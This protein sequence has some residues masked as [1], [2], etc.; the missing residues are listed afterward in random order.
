MGTV[1]FQSEPTGQEA[2]AAAETQNTPPSA[3]GERPSWLPQDFTGTP[4][5]YVASLVKSQADT[6]AELT[7][8]QQELAK[9]QKPADEKKPDEAKDE[10]KDDLEIEDEPKKEEGP[11]PVDFAPYTQEFN[12]TGDVSQESRA[13][14]I[15]SLKGV[16]GDNTE[17]IVNDY[18]EGA[19][20][21]VSNTTSQIKGVAGGDEGYAQMVAWASE[22]LSADEKAAYNRAVNSGDFH[23]ASFAVQGLKSKYE[24]ANGKSPKLINGDNGP[25]S[26]GGFKSL[27]ELKTA[28][29]D[30]RYKTDPDYR[31]SV[32]A[33][34]AKSNI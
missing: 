13:K 16:F 11:A 14:I 7:R 32:E 23:T 19:K 26:S 25:A 28:I 34:A 4:E 6:K 18:I 30:P 2:P 29:A 15:D 9:Y 24:A 17:G 5:E 33:R 10:K 22:N 31:K 20:N 27:H 21:R 3:S 1:V 8:A 12:E